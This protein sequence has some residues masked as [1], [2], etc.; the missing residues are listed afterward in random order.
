MLLTAVGVE[1]FISPHP[2]GCPELNWSLSLFILQGKNGIKYRERKITAVLLRKINTN[3]FLFVSK[4][5][6]CDQVFLV[7]LTAPKVLGVS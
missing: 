6:K 1:V 4:H 5:D 7:F 2:E 3:Q